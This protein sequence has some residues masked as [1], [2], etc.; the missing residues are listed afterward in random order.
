MSALMHDML[1]VPRN[2]KACRAQA[3][4]EWH[5]TVQVMV[6]RHSSTASSAHL[7][8]QALQRLRKFMHHVGRHWLGMV[9]LYHTKTHA[10]TWRCGHAGL[11]GS[12][13]RECHAS[14]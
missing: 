1:K 3:L 11:R 8:K 7:R 13:A 6:C 5:A 10:E 2:S 12:D 14:E 9:C 4:L